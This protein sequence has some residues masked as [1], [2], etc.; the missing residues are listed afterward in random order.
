MRLNLLEDTNDW[1]EG[2]V[3]NDCDQPVIG[4][5]QAAENGGNTELGSVSMNPTQPLVFQSQE[6]VL[7]FDEQTEIDQEN[8]LMELYSA[9]DKNLSEEMNNS[10]GS[11]TQGDVNMDQGHSE[12]LEEVQEKTDLDPET[13]DLG[14]IRGNTKYNLR[15]RPE[16]NRRYST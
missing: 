15:E 12:V 3:T 13:R 9:E 10:Q 2:D 8:A 1:T 5:A 14:K 11:M 6:P 7:S 16:L 4:S